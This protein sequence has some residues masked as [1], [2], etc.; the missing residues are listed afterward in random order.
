MLGNFLSFCKYNGLLE[1]ANVQLK[2]TPG[3]IQRYRNRIVGLHEFDRLIKQIGNQTRDER[4]AQCVCI[5]AFYGGLR[6]DEIRRLSINDVYVCRN[7]IRI[8]VQYGK[9]DAARRAIPISLPAQAS[10]T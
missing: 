6:A 4:I 5:L 7:E 8:D 9:S 1:R 3:G 10:A 2:K